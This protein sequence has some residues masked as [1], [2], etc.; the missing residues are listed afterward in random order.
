MLRLHAIVK[1][2]IAEYGCAKI[3]STLLLDECVVRGACMAEALLTEG[4]LAIATHTTP[5]EYTDYQ[6]EKRHHDLVI[7]GC[8]ETPATSDKYT[9]INTVDTF[10]DQD[11]KP[12][13]CTA[14]LII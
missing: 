13:N 1:K 3:S 4:K 14:T 5:F 6:Q 11:P 2:A 8:G 9:V 12:H 10:K 7:L